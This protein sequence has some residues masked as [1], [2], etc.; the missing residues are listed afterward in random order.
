MKPPF[1]EYPPN[2]KMIDAD[3]CARHADDWIS[4]VK[5]PQ[6]TAQSKQ[7]GNAS[8]MAEAAKRDKRFAGAAKAAEKAEKQIAARKRMLN[9]TQWQRTR[10]IPGEMRA[11]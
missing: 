11:T 8:W 6:F 5:M 4:F 1:N 3:K 9:G 2:V 10:Y 7:A